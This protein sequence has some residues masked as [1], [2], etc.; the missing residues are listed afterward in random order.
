MAPFN[1]EMGNVDETVDALELGDSRVKRL[2][3]CKNTNKLD[4]K[5]DGPSQKMIIDVTL[6]VRYLFNG[7]ESY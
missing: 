7:E 2:I 1:L 5:Y 3:S 6:K 4:L